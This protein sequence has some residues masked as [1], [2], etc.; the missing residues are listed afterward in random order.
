M[1][2]ITSDDTMK[3]VH[4][5]DV[6]PRLGKGEEGRRRV[7]LRRKRLVVLKDILVRQLLA[8]L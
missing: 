1:A 2:Q 4:Q 3:G 7:S 8:S 6:R 5:V